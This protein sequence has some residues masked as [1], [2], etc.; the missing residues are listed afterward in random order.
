MCVVSVVIAACVTAQTARVQRRPTVD[1]PRRR[2]ITNTVD[3]CQRC[4]RPTYTAIIATVR[5]TTRLVQH[6]EC[7]QCWPLS[8][9]LSSAFIIPDPQT[10]A[11]AS[12]TP[13]RILFLQCPEIG[14][15][16]RAILVSRWPAYDPEASLTLARQTVYT[17]ARN[18]ACQWRKNSWYCA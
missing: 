12:C 14:A 1:V 16:S 4:R 6:I 17:T 8:L 10:A 2:P 9:S 13:A 7:R 11:K 5:L 18:L 3:D 15:P